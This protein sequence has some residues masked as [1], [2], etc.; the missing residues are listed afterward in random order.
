MS[1]QLRGTMLLDE[2]MAKHCSWRCGGKVKRYFVPADV[3]DLQT[4]LKQLPADEDIVWVGLGSNL[5]VRDAGFDGTV[6]A[7]QGVF[8]Q[9]ELASEKNTVKV[10]AG[11][12]DAKL[13]RFCARNQLAGGEFFAGIP[14]L[15][16]G[17]LAMNAGAFGGET[18]R[19]VVSVETLDRAGELHQRTPDEYEIGYRHTQLKNSQQTEWFVSAIM[20][21]ER[22]VEENTDAVID[23]KQLLAKRAATQPIGAASCGSVFRNPENDYAARLI[24]SCGLKGKRLGGAVVSEKHANF[25]LNEGHASANDIEQLIEQVQRLVFEKH[26]IELRTEV[27]IVGE[28]LS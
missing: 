6:I 13:A 12:A 10:G 28:K 21:F 15:V 24:E 17:A 5:L 14:G 18:W 25:I 19:H 22:H 3:E 7:T 1:A 27:R 9:L 20:R 4:L 16:G 23:I 2:P 8:N 26:G 11:V